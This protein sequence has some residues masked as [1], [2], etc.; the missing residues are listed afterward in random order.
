VAGFYS[1]VDTGICGNDQ[2]AEEA[3]KTQLGDKN[4]IT[5]PVEAAAIAAGVRI[6]V[7]SG[8]KKS[9]VKPGKDGDAATI[10]LASSDTMT[11]INDDG[12][13]ESVAAVITEVLEHEV[14]HI[15]DAI[16]MSPV[17]EPDVVTSSQ[18]KERTTRKGVSESSAINRTNIYR[19]NS[20]Q[21]RQRYC[22]SCSPSQA[23][24][25]NKKK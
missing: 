9:Q 22:H 15:A 4:S 16:G 2:D 12:S 11:V 23:R 5:G 20:R 1:A 25:H 6:G 13:I 21:T 18:F 17:G 24:R 10:D 7:N 14:G 19:R 8:A 3:I